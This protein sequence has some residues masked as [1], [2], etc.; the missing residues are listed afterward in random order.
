MSLATVTVPDAFF[1]RRALSA[2]ANGVS[3]SDVLEILDAVARFEWSF[4]ARRFDALSDLL[5]DDVVCDHIFGLRS[6][7]AQVMD[8]LQNV[9]PYHG[10]R[11]QSTNATV[12]IDSDGS[13]AALSYLVVVQV[14]TESGANDPFPLIIADAL[15]TDTM[16]R[17]DGRWKIAKRTFEQ[18]KVTKQ[19]LPD[20]A[21]RIGFEA[22]AVE[23]AARERASAR[24]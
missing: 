22:T 13:P 23:R 7:K 9:I 15:V 16:R 21:T 4:D 6:G 12:F 8:M 18:M 1:Q 2:G 17:V 19:Y 5:T 3:A 11:H 14:S 10:L 24:R 20:D